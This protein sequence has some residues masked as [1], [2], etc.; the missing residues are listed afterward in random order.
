[1]V[2]FIKQPTN[3]MKKASLLC[4]ICICLLSACA[5]INF[6]EGGDKIVSNHSKIAIIPTNVFNI[7][8]EEVQNNECYEYLEE[9]SQKLYLRL[10]VEVAKR[11]NKKKNVIELVPPSIT[12]KQLK[13]AGIEYIN[14]EDYNALCKTL[15]V[16]AVLVA[17]F[18]V[19]QPSSVGAS[20]ATGII[21]AVLFRGIGAASVTNAIYGDVFIYD[22]NSAQK[23][24]SYEHKAKGD[25]LSSKSTV[26]NSLVKNLAKKLPYF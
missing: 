9:E 20:V 16:D 19:R 10:A 4:L 12:K 25:F 5:K 17:D 24:W 1:M 21:S 26:Y 14:T 2:S 18:F 6:V 15:D 13:D 11:N 23:I 8:C 3:I 22:S 7:V